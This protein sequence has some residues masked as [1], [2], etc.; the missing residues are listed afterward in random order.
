MTKYNLSWSNKFK[1]VPWT[2]KLFL[3]CFSAWIRKGQPATF[4]TKQWCFCEILVF[5]TKNVSKITFCFLADKC[6]LQKNCLPD[7]WK[8][9]IFCISIRNTR[10]PYIFLNNFS[11]NSL[12]EKCKSKETKNRQDWYLTRVSIFHCLFIT[13]FWKISFCRQWPDRP[14]LWFYH[15]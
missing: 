15:T 13:G 14:P 11:V 2:E 12:Q 7:K 6:N 8:H 9:L 5:S 10:T 1:R 3:N 4:K